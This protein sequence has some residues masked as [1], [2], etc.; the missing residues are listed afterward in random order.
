MGGFSFYLTAVPVIIPSMHMWSRLWYWL[1]GAGL[2]LF[3]GR[4]LAEL[5]ASRWGSLAWFTA[6]AITLLCVLV[7][8]GIWHS[9]FSV[10]YSVFSNQYSAFTWPLLLLW[11]YVAWPQPDW[12]WAAVV[13]LLTGLTMLA[14][15][16]RQADWPRLTPGQVAAALAV[17]GGLLYWYTLV[18][19][20]LPADSGEFQ[21]VAATLGVAHPPGFPLYTLLGHLFTRLPGLTPAYAL[22]LFAALTSSLTLYLV[23]L[24]AYRLTQQHLASLTAV[25]TLATATTF[26]SQATTANVRSLTALFAAFVIYHLICFRQ[27][28]VDSVET[29]DRHLLWAALGLGFGLTHHA[30]LLFMGLVFGVALLL[31]DPS[32]LRQPRRWLRPLLAGLA[33]LLPWLYLPWRAWAGV[34]EAAGLATW[35]GFWDHVLARGFSGDF[36]YFA[37]PD[38]LWQRLG[39]MGNVLTFQFN[40]WLLLGMALGGLLLLW[41]DRRLALLLLGSFGLHTLI[42]AV[43]R[44]PQT[45]EYM[46]PAYVPLALMLAYLVDFGKKLRGD[47]QRSRG[48]VLSAAEVDT[49]RKTEEKTVPF[50]FIRV[51]SYPC[52][53]TI[54]MAILLTAALIQGWHHYPSYAAL[55]RQEDARHYA[56]RLLDEAPPGGLILAHWHWFTPLRYLQAV[57]EQRP[58]VEVEFVFPRGEPYDETWGRLAGEAWENGR[59][60]ITTHYAEFVYEGLPPPQPLGEAFLFAQTPLTDLPAGFAPLDLPLGETIQVR[61]I[62][63]S[64]LAI[65]ETAVLTLAWEPIRT[66]TEPLSLFAHLVGPDDQLYAQADLPARPQPDGLT[67]TRFYLTPR[68]GA[69][70]G[71]YT[72]MI[73]GY[74]SEPL[75]HEG[76]ARTAISTLTLTPRAT[77]LYTQNRL[78]RPLA[79]RPLAGTLAQHQR[80]VGYDWDHTLPDIPRLYLHWRTPDGYFSQVYDGSEPVSLPA[81]SG[82]WGIRQEWSIPRS[83]GS[84]HYVPL[85]QGLIWLGE[86]RLPQPVS[87]REITLPQRLAGSQPVLRDLVISVRLVGYEPDEFHWAWT[88]LQDGVPAMGAIP[89][90]KWIGGSEVVSPYRLAV[91]ETA[92]SGQTIGGFVRFYDAFTNEPLPILDERL[93]EGLPGI[94]LSVSRYR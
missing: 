20:L 76:E 43:Y 90:L 91:G 48:L 7:M 10:R 69:L 44:A 8:P 88:D 65:G 94:P 45:V 77:P 66:W 47:A 86:N 89:T 84:G 17:L 42:T 75:L 87:Q 55:S 63:L 82:P 71:D 68:P 6:A 80:L 85:G 50:S 28:R 21:L 4:L 16:A 39:V 32:L 57:E 54:A 36:F 64:G 37:Q 23:Y 33:G 40:G 72:L 92:V 59:S 30:S 52:L 56:Q 22:N 81:T 49:Q 5:F 34:P 60:V 3:A 41:R 79:Q 53:Q 67:L 14:G 74:G 61:G 2:G 1:P 12:Q 29:A 51:F 38:L 46:L 27:A 26:W 93:S 70:P 73:G 62:D 25:L 13:G 19:G 24:T 31:F 15:A 11:L 78:R 9:I 58:D 83:T 18:P 35:Q